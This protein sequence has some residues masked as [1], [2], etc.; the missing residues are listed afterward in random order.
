MRLKAT[1]VLEAHPP[2]AI[3]TCRTGNN[4]PGVGNLPTGFTSTSTR[5]FPRQTT[6]KEEP[7]KT[8]FATDAWDKW[9]GFKT[10]KKEN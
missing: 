7:T 2:K 9:D 3:S 5:T 1:A 10:S 6:R 8:S 4:P